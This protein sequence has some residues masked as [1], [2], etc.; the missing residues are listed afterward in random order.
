MKTILIALT[1]F[2]VSCTKTNQDI[3]NVFTPNG[4]GLNDTWVLPFEN[5]SIIIFN[6]AGN[7]VY[8]ANP[9]LNDWNADGIANGNNFYS[10]KYNGNNYRGY[11]YITR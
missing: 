11:V 7:V 6:T 2:L 1:L 5:A 9:Y 3:P 10:V 8:R 4:D